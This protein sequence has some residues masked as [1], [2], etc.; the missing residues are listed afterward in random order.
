VDALEHGLGYEDI[1][2]GQGQGNGERPV[3]AAVQV[4]QFVSFPGYPEPVDQ[5]VQGQEVNFVAV[6]DG[7]EGQADGEVGFVDS[8]WPEDQDVLAVVNK[9]EG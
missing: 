9:P 5:V 1:R 4:R 8:G 6:F 3:S 7:F 2:F